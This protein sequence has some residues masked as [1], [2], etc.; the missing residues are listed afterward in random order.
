[1]LTATQVHAAGRYIGSHWVP[2]GTCYERSKVESLAKKQYTDKVQKIQRVLDEAY[3]VDR[4]RVQNA[5]NVA[6]KNAQNEYHKLLQDYAP[7]FCSE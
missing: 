5:A 4:V 2:A 7:V 6:R 3:N 1:M